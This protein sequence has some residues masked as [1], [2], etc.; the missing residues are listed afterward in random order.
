MIIFLIQ[1]VDIIS[2]ILILVIIAD[3]VLSF[4]MSPY[5]PVRETMGRFLNPLY[6]PIRRFVRPIGG[7]DLSPLILLILIQILAALIR[8]LLISLL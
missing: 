7:L 8:S 3:A 4:F 5:H 1:L 6:S 2:R